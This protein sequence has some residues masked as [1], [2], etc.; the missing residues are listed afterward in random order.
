MLVKRWFVITVKQD[1]TWRALDGSDHPLYSSRLLRRTPRVGAT[2]LQGGGGGGEPKTQRLRRVRC[3][4]DRR[5]NRVPGFRTR[6]AT[7]DRLARCP[8]LSKPRRRTVLLF[9]RHWTGIRQCS[10]RAF[11]RSLGNRGTR[12]GQRII[13]KHAMIERPGRLAGQ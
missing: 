4:A 6:A 13:R 10:L 9:Q 11:T 8:R 3:K 2:L 12:P 5:C 1:Q 7:A